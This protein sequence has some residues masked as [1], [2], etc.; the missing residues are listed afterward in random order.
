M[1]KREHWHG[2]SEEKGSNT[3]PLLGFDCCVELTRSGARMT[4]VP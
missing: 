4:I 1:K 2:V 3:A